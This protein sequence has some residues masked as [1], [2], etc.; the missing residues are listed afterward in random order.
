MATSTLMQRY[1]EY[2]DRLKAQGI[3]LIAFECPACKQAIETQPA[4]KGD[5]WDS[6]AE[7]PHCNVMYMKITQGKKARGLIPQ[8]PANTTD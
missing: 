8:V 2:N 7:C 1:T 3:K 6:L 4:P 5:V